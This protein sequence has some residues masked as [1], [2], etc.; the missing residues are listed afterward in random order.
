[1]SA[2]EVPFGGSTECGWV[3][4]EVA[5]GEGGWVHEYSG[6]RTVVSPPALLG[7]AERIIMAH[8]M[9]VEAAKAAAAA[10]A[11]SPP[12]TPPDIE[13]KEQALSL[14][15]MFQ[16]LRAARLKGRR[17][18]TVLASSI[19]PASLEGKELKRLFPGITEEEVHFYKHRL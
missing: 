12:S 2:W 10:E 9:E 1:V 7:E 15:G 17:K 16:T 18:A 5:W 11:P 6:T 3:W 4:E 14:A 19:P 8:L 13:P